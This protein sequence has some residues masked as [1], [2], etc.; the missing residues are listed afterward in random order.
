MTG[1]MIA[2]G[3]HNAG[4]SFDEAVALTIADKPP[5]LVEEEEREVLYGCNMVFRGGA[6]GTVRFD[7][8]L[9]LY[10]WLEDVDFAYLVGAKG[11]LIKT[12]RL[13]SVHMGTKRGRTSGKRL[14]Y[15]QVVNPIYLRRKKTIPRKLARQLLF[16]N[17]ASNLLRSLH[18]E[19]LVDRRGRLLGNLIGIV[20]LFLRRAHPRRIEQF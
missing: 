5:A 20:D 17:V 7:E 13:N 19:P 14:G 15:S 2:D 11:K 12:S 9:P 16:Q 18:P 10:G 3:I 1:R 6:I 8:D 4:Y